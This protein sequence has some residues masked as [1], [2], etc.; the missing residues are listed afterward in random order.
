MGQIE[1]AIPRKAAAVVDFDV[2]VAVVAVYFFSTIFFFDC[3]IQRTAKFIYWKKMAMTFLK[4]LGHKSGGR[5]T[6][7]ILAARQIQALSLFHVIKPILKIG[8]SMS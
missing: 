1:T 2:V 4:H 5:K 8:L 3:P 6:V 7:S